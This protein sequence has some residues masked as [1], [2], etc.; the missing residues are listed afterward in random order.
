MRYYSQREFGVRK[1]VIPAKTG[2]QNIAVSPKTT[3]FSI[4]ISGRTFGFGEA[5][6]VP[7]LFPENSIVSY[8]ELMLVRKYL[9]VAL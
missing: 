5:I 4:E 8:A 9:P 3:V 2:I 7:Q 6:S 1:L